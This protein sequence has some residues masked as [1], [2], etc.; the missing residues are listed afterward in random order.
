MWMDWA[1]ESNRIGGAFGAPRSRRTLVAIVAVAIVG[2]DL[3]ELVPF[4]SSARILPVALACLAAGFFT[5][6]DRKS[7]GLL[8]S[9]LQG[10]WYW[11]RA[12]LLIGVV[13][14][15]LLGAYIAI[16]FVVDPAA[17]EVL[18]MGDTEYV[19]RWIV[20]ACVSAPL[21]EEAIYRWVLCVGLV[22]CLGRT[23][24]IIA[25]GLVFGFLHV[26]YGNPSPENLLGGFILAW[27]FFKSGTLAVPIAL[28]AVGNGAI[29]VGHGVYYLLV[30][31][32]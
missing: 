16:V 14:G 10:W 32:S 9:P 6:W 30:S 20:G 19:W 29:I 11:V 4:H 13:M 28:H 24:T 1:R 22:S 23:P 26:R 27:T 17:F 25:S 2:G 7:L 3:A 5:G 31:A 18:P 15:V 21:V 12:T 8:A